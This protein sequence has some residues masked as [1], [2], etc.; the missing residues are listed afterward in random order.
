M[1]QKNNKS[2]KEWEGFISD[3]GIK[4]SLETIE[5][6]LKNN[7][8]FWGMT[9]IQLNESA[10]FKEAVKEYN[11]NNP[12]QFTESEV[13]EVESLISKIPK[14]YAITN[15]KLSNE[16]TKE[17]VNRGS[18]S[19][20]VMN[21]DK[22]NEVRTYNSLTYDDKNISIT[23]RQEFTAYDRA[24]H[25]AVCSLYAAG[26][27][28]ITPSMVYRAV[29][30]MTETEKVSEQSIEAVKKSLDK[31]RFLRLKVDFTEE[32]KARGWNVDKTE[33]DSYLLPAK[34][35]IVEAGGNK[36]EAYKIFETPELYKYSQRSKQIISIPLGLLD[37]KEATR[38]TEEII[39]IKEYLIR[40]IEIMKHN[41]DM[42]RKIIYDTIFEESGI[43]ITD[44][45]HKLRIR[46]YITSILSLWQTRDKYIKNFKEYK[47]GN[48]FKGIAISF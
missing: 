20:G 42:S 22:K 25:N 41:K 27:D 44:K 10:Q 7:P 39:S 14:T 33:I 2:E 28:I 26:N 17:F 11:K 8:Q 46:E 37:T 32:A 3:I 5:A 15:N 13:S 29:T 19:L 23:G 31:S 9:L 34:V 35:V 36:L 47:E 38:N 6:V 40:R 16:M 4:V 12:L 43:T 21:I 1:E 45:K 18:I 24:I 48:A 30:G